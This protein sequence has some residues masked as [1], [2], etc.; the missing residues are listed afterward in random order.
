MKPVHGLLDNVARCGELA[1]IIFASFPI[2]RIVIDALSV[3]L[4]RIEIA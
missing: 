1:E 2:V 3:Q 4:K